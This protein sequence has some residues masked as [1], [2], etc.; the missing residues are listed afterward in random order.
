MS[1]NETCC[2]ECEYPLNLRGYP[3]L[4]QK[5]RCSRC[6]ANLIVTNLE[7]IDLDVLLAASRPV[8]FKKKGPLVEVPCSECDQSIKLSTHAHLGHQ[9]VC[10]ACGVLLEVVNTRPLEVEQS[11]VLNLK[12]SGRRW[13]S[14]PNIF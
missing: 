1:R 9:L 14:N 5:V 13:R 2:P 12:Q 3:Y 11:M 6:E 4:G 7:P 8:N 10:D